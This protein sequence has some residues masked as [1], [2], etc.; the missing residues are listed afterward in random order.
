M[1]FSIHCN[2]NYCMLILR[3]NCECCLK[4]SIEQPEYLVCTMASCTVYGVRYSFFSFY[5]EIQVEIQNRAY[6]PY[7][8]SVHIHLNKT[9]SIKQVSGTLKGDYL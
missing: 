6:W 1:Y 3:L 2:A 9:N 7:P 4:V 5:W 8:G